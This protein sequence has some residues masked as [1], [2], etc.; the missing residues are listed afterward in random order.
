MSRPRIGG[1]AADPLVDRRLRRLRELERER[2]VLLDGHV[3]VEGVVLEHHGDVAVLGR[4]L[5]DHPPA[6]RDLALGDLLEPGH[7]PQQRGLAAARGADQ[8]DELAVRD[9]DLDA[10]QDVRAA[11]VLVDLAD[12]D[13]CHL[14]LRCGAA[15]RRFSP[16]PPRASQAF[17]RMM[18]PPADQF[19]AR[20]GAL[21]YI[22]R[23]AWRGR[24]C[25]GA[26]AK[27]AQHERAKRRCRPCGS[28][29]RSFMSP[30]CGPHWSC[31]SAPSAC[32]GASLIRAGSMA[33][34]TPAPPC[35]RSRRT[36]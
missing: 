4:D 12:L 8:D 30:T 17:G 6:D 34:W 33:S 31:T 2:H 9:V 7:H 21:P 3:R 1:G 10:V 36:S 15:T 25:A 23:G 24:G 5:V 29:G 11:E 35:W 19:N 28:A 13:R 27:D 14:P 16:D 20:A 22:D 18:P 26:C 32:G